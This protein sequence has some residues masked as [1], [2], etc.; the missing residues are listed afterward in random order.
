MT[1]AHYYAMMHR[2]AFSLPCRNAD[3]SLIKYWPGRGLPASKAAKCAGFSGCNVTI[4]CVEAGI[5]SLIKK[6]FTDLRGL[7]TR[8]AAGCIGIS[9]MFHEITSDGSGPPLASQTLRLREE[10]GPRKSV[11]RFRPVAGLRHSGASRS[12]VV[13]ATAVNINL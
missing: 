5:D 10:S 1:Q 8:R 7:H 3:H 13:M 2:Q 4:S 9:A 11:P 6:T 12:C